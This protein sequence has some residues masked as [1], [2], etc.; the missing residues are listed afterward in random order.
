[1]KKLIVILLILGMFS[2]SGILPTEENSNP[3]IW[4]SKINSWVPFVT[5]TSDGSYTGVSSLDGSFYIMDNKGEV[6]WTDKPGHRVTSISFSDDLSKVSVVTG[7]RVYIYTIN[8]EFL[9]TYK[10]VQGGFMDITPDG[11]Y[12][13]GSS[14]NIYAM[15]YK[16]GRPAWDYKTDGKV[17]DISLTPDG[18]TLGIASSDNYVYLIRSGLL[19]WKQDLKAPVIS[20]EVTP[21][22]SYVVCGT[23][24]FESD[25]GSKDFKLYLFDGSGKL[26]WSKNMGHTVSSVSITPDAS[27]I[28]AGAWDKK[29]HIFS[30]SGE[31]LKQFEAEG[32][33][34][35]VSITPN[36]KSL[37][38]GSTD[39]YVYFLDVDSMQKHEGMASSL[40]LLYLAIPVLLIIAAAAIIYTK[41]VKK[42]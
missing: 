11:T 7:E 15:V 24:S 9:T 25:E 10:S 35:S 29:A 6:L 33:V 17:N 26:L 2:S 16:D 38:V 22:S 3:V 4:K 23:G 34:W 8:G 19:L 31:P 27:Y 28:A 41:K 18:Q 32:N 39:T 30:K 21:D 37:V 5:T 42:K 14:S 36:G 20:V 12:I 13:G 1:M 40:N